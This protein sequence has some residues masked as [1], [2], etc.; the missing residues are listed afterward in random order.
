MRRFRAWPALV[1]LVVGA[2]L[3]VYLIVALSPASSLRAETQRRRVEDAVRFAAVQ[4]YALEGAYP[5]DEEYLKD[6]YGVQYNE[7][8]FFVHYKPNGANLAPDIQVILSLN[9]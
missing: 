3:L 7:S 5:P 4:C 2:S 8:L 1:S 6:H 9:E